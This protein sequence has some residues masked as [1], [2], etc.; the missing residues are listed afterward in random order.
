[1]PIG[2][3]GHLQ[4]RSAE[5]AVKLGDGEGPILAVQQQVVE[6]RVADLMVAQMRVGAERVAFRQAR[7]DR[8]R[9][10]QTILRRTRQ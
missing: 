4:P 2:R 8:L 3:A 6:T 1:M 7:E 5:R 9:R 10:L